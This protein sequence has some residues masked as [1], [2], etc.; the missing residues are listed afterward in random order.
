MIDPPR[1]GVKEAVRTCKKAGIKTVMITYMFLPCL[2][3]FTIVTKLSSANI[4][5]EAF[6]AT[7]VPFF[8]IAIPISV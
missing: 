7:S 5:S 4:I 3:A 2:T 6:L 1:D 8:P